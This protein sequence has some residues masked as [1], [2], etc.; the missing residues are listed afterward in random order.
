MPSRVVL[1]GGK[2]MGYW[3]GIC[4]R[5]ILSTKI[6]EIPGKAI[7]TT[8]RKIPPRDKN[9]ELLDLEKNNFREICKTK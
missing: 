2:L 3:T 5:I 1:F 4:L 8:P 6:I 7:Q 9:I